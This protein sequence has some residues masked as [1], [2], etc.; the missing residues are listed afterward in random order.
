MVQILSSNNK[1]YQWFVFSPTPESPET[2]LNIQTRL[3]KTMNN[4]RKFEHFI[5]L[6]I[7]KRLG[8]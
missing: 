1:S 6:E 7:R 2:E 8:K 3:I 4:T 5:A